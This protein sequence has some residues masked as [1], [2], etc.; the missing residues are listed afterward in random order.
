MGVRDRKRRGHAMKCL[1]V[2]CVLAV[3]VAFG[4]ETDLGHVGPYPDPTITHLD[5][6]ATDAVIVSQPFIFA[7][8]TNALGCNASNSWMIADDC[9]PAGTANM[10]QW[11]FWVLYTGSTATTW[12]IAIRN[13]G[14]GPGTTV[15]WTRDVVGCFN[16][17]T[18]LYGWG[19]LVYSVIATL[20]PPFYTPVAGTKIWLCYQ[21][22]NGSGT[23]YFCATNQTWADQCYFSANNGTSWSS[24]T[25]NWGVAYELTMIVCSTFALERDTWGSIKSTF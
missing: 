13:N 11:Q 9:T 5:F 3:G 15:L 10:G 7:N 20:V 6:P 21:S 24:S 19:Y 17:S 25:S 18:G 16:T 1:F 12:K 4:T 8:M 14:T 22:Q 23:T 2:L